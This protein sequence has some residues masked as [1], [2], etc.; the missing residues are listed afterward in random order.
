MEDAGRTNLQQKKKITTRLIQ[1]ISDTVA[2]DT[3]LRPKTRRGASVS[4]TQTRRR[5]TYECG[6]VSRAR[7]IASHLSRTNAIRP[8]SVV[9]KKFGWHSPS[10]P[11]AD[12]VYTYA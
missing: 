11:N 12:V 10:V 9:K 4:G 5:R 6:L 7:H 2:F 8:E 3:L 1:S